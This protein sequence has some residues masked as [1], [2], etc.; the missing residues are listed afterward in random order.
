MVLSERVS[1]LL[2]NYSGQ[3]SKSIADSIRANLPGTE[4]I[5][6]SD[7][8]SLTDSSTPD[9]IIILSENDDAELLPTVKTLV[10]R[11]KDAR[12]L[13]IPGS[14]QNAV[15]AYCLQQD[16]GH[17]LPLDSLPLLPD[18]LQQIIKHQLKI[19]K[20]LSHLEKQQ[21]AIVSLATGSGLTRGN[22]EQALKDITR[23]TAE[24]LGIS[25]VSIWRYNADHSSII[26]DILYNAASNSYEQ[27]LELFENSYP[28]YFEALMENRVIAAVDA[29]TDSATIEFSETY[30]KPNGIV[31]MLDAPI[32]VQG[33]MIGVVCHEQVGTIRRWSY[34]DQ[35]FAGAIADLVA[36]SI[37]NGERRRAEDA[38]RKR[39]RYLKEAEAIAHLGNFEADLQTRAITWSDEVYQIFGRKVGSK[40]TWDIYE[41]LLAKEDYQRVMAA[42]EQAISAKTSY[43]IEHDLVLEDGARKHLFV[44]MR[45]I[46]DDD[47]EV[48]KLFGIVQDITRIKQA[49]DERIELQINQEKIAF[50]QD[51]I[52]S[53]THDLK[54]P[55]TSILS[56]TYL[57]KRVEDKERQIHHLNR[58]DEQVKRLQE[59][60][61]AILTVSRLEH[62]PR[63]DFQTYDL[64][65]LIEEVVHQS[66]A[67][68]TKKDI[69]LQIDLHPEQIK[70]DL[71]Y[72]EILRALY[73]LVENAIN[74][75]P[76]NGTVTISTGRSGTQI[77]CSIHDTGIGIEAEDL[78]HV[79]EQFYRAKNARSFEKGTG[80]G[81]SIVKKIIDLHDGEIS[82]KSQPGKGTGVTITLQSS[83]KTSAST[84]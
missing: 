23:T 13:F 48:I 38:L 84:G 4:L 40:I 52:D 29:H 80:L 67:N 71:A 50:L 6:A 42:V 43:S 26:C 15:A 32:R 65:R 55:L 10:S 8:K 22:R 75:T 69:Q 54:T 62:L 76:E 41:S 74:Y 17:Y 78:P 45:P 60:I 28:Q 56:N 30:L 68:A 34:D 59:M 44:I 19:K 33:Q 79:F 21:Q 73:N 7:I 47:G 37:E 77:R 72:T 81:L 3:Y 57:T 49:E 35:Q 18:L 9:I 24:T 46:L 83:V 66:R 25:R 39:E 12:L 70:V 63:L 31:S 64:N 82:I 58:I 11:F 20:R 5:L 2:F 16:D 14:Q 61:D 53:M 51:F 1:I 27:G 36:L